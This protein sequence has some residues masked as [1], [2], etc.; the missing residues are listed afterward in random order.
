MVRDVVQPVYWLA[1]AF[2]QAGVQAVST[3]FCPDLV[4]FSSSVFGARVD[5]SCLPL[6]ICNRD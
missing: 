3:A 4:S 5:F 2:R 1:G 6:Q